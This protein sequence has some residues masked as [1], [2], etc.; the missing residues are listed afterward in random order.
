MNVSLTYHINRFVLFVPLP[1]PLPPQDMASSLKV[2]LLE[3]SAKSSDNVERAFLTMAS[4]IHKRVAKEGAGMQG[5]SREARAQ[6]AKISS[7]PVW[8][9][10]EKQAPEAST[11][12]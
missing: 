8:L 9:G 2:P 4:E 6:S 1:L 10:G 5:E 12:C 7:A 11:C 3:T